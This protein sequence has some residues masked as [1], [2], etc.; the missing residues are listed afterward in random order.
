MDGLRRH[1]WSIIVASASLS[2]RVASTTITSYISQALFLYAINLI[3]ANEVANNL[4][5]TVISCI[6]WF[7]QPFREKGPTRDAARELVNRLI[8][9]TLYLA[10][11]VTIHRDGWILHDIY[12][13]R[14][15]LKVSFSRLVIPYA[16][17]TLVRTAFPAVTSVLVAAWFFICSFARYYWIM[18]RKVLAETFFDYQ[19]FLSDLVAKYLINSLEHL[20]YHLLLRGLIKAIWG[21]SAHTW[22]NSFWY[23]MQVLYGFVQ[24]TRTALEQY[25]YSYSPSRDNL[26][27]RNQ[28]TLDN[29][30]E[31]EYTALPEGHVRLLLLHPRHPDNEIRCSILVTPLTTAP[32]FEAMSYTWGPETDEC[33]KI[34]VDGATVSVRSNAFN[35]LRDRSSY[36]IPRLLWIDSICINQNDTDERNQQ[37]RLMGQIYSTASLVTIWLSS[38]TGQRTVLSEFTDTVRAVLGLSMFDLFCVFDDIDQDEDRFYKRFAGT[39]RNTWISPRW[40]ELIKLLNNAWFGRV[41]V[42]QEVVLAAQVRVLYDR[43]EVDW[44]SLQSG[45]SVLIRKASNL[46]EWTDQPGVRQRSQTFKMANIDVIRGLRERRQ[47]GESISFVEVLQIIRSFQAKDQ[48]DKVF[49]TQG[50]CDKPTV[51][52]PEPDYRKPLTDVY[53]D[54]A[55]RIVREHGATRAMSAAGIGYRSLDDNDE[56]KGLPSWV[57]DVRQQQLCANLSHI[58][59]AID[60]KAGG[61][62][63]GEADALE[64]PERRRLNISAAMIGLITELA[65]QHVIN[66]YG[67]VYPEQDLT[68]L[69]SVLSASSALVVRSPAAQAMYTARSRTIDAGGERHWQMLAGEVLWRTLI[70][71]RTTAVRPAPATME[72]VFVDFVKGMREAQNELLNGTDPMAAAP[73]NLTAAFTGGYGRNST[74]AWGNRRL[75]ILAEGYVGLVPPLARHGDAVFLVQGAQTPFVFRQTPVLG[76]YELVGECYM[77]GIMDGEFIEGKD[78]GRMIVV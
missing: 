40:D 51:E 4:R 20:I 68:A 70:G 62:P 46:V 11:T 7:S 43:V 34:A 25:K 53:I 66:L 58:S 76:E 5:L 28:A 17:F 63:G 22:F 19:D 24:T 26:R 72:K 56:L 37:V 44:E 36:F 31:F 41:W 9:Y 14:I 3:L 67:P 12:F 15:L 52:W 18:L 74:R 35:L 21:Y 50:F 23:L 27:I 16:G 69:L 42:V 77:H 30:P 29:L 78:F 60:Y 65:P 45:F 39:R 49:G 73:S 6:P 75:A 13:T 1:S 2:F 71:D 48:R 8:P 57:P 32:R 54:A 47:K 64:N 33:F 55:V 59:A 10:L 61:P 38:A